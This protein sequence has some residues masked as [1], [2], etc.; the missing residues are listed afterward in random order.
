MDRLVNWIEIPVTDITRAKAFY[1]AVLGCELADMPVQGLKYAIFPAKSATNCGALVQG[2]GYSPSATG[3]VLY[4]DGTARMDELLARVSAAGGEVLM[5]VTRLS[6]EAGDVAFFRDSEGNRIGLQSP[7]PR[8]GAVT[9]DE[10]QRLLGSAPKRFAF[11]L[12][13]GPKFGPETQALQW[14]HARNMFALLQAGRLA[15]V[16]ALMDGTDVLG[17]GVIEA[18]SK[19]DVET[20]LREDPAVSGGRLRFEIFSAASFLRGEV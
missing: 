10:M 15:S 16:T 17:L 1:S 2:D 18:A 13:P 12:R 9:D 4:L 6:K 8:S 5:P 14:E 3:P 11:L 20:L 7:E 19:A